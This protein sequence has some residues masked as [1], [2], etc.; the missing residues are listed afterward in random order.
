M[1][2][3][4]KDQYKEEAQLGAIRPYSKAPVRINKGNFSKKERKKTMGNYQNGNNQGYNGYNGRNQGGYGGN[5][6]NGNAGYNGRNQG[7]Y[8]GNQNQGNGGYNANRGQGNGGYPNNQGGYGGN[9]N[10]GNNQGNN[11]APRPTRNN[12]YFN[13]EGAQFGTVEGF[14]NDVTVREVTLKS[15]EK[16]MVA[17]VKLSIVLT[18]YHRQNLSKALGGEVPVRQNGYTIIRVA[19]WG[20]TAEFMQN[21]A[22]QHGQR[23]F[24]TVYNF[25]LSQ[26]QGQDGSART[27][28]SAV[29][30]DSLRAISAARENGESALDYEARRFG[31]GGNQGGYQNQGNGGYNNNQG[32]GNNGYNNPSHGNQG[33]G[34][35]NS[36]GQNQSNAP[37]SNSYDEF[38]DFASS[39]EELDDDSQLPF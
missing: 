13:E 4:G 37:Q 12:I 11:N 1:S 15:G 20:R 21:H 28:L 10:R 36:R 34:G 26:F 9:Q 14:V 33:N 35:Y 22:P 30:V 17:E 29:G 27:S 7:G 3:R 8:G 24:A 38:G 16:R 32:Q 5:Q 19:Y 2:T 39:Y 6:N 18:D 25:T 31:N 23:A